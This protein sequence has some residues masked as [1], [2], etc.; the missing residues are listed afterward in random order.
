MRIPFR[1]GIVRAPSNFLQLTSGKV[2]LSIPPSQ[3]LIMAFADGA[4]DYLVT[5]RLSAA[6]AWTGPFVGGSQS[7]WLFWDL[8]TVTGAKTYGHTLLEPVEGSVAPVSPLNDQHWFD[9]V[10]NKM[11]VWNSTVSRWIPKIRVFAGKL[12]NGAIFVSMSIS[13][14]VYTG[15]QIGNLQSIAVDAGAL[16]FDADGY[17]VKKANGTFLTTEDVVLTGVASSSHVKFGSIVLEAEATESIA[18]FSIVRFTDFNQVSVATNYVLDNAAYGIV[19]VDANSGDVVSITMEGLISNSDWDWSAAGINA[20]LY[21]DI[22]GALTTVAPPTPIAVAAV[23]DTTSILLRPSSLF[24]NSGNDPATTLDMGSVLLSVA[25]ADVDLPIA[26]GDNDPRVT[27]TLA[28]ISDAASHL[29][30]Q[31]NT[32]LDGVTSVTGGIVVRR[33]TDGVGIN[34]TLTAPAAGI[35]ITNPTGDL[36]NPT[37]ALANDLA[38]VEGLAATGLA[39][40]TGT[41]TWATRSVVTSGPASGKGV[42]VTNGDAVAGNVSLALDNDAGAIE[43]LIGVGLPVRIADD[44]W[45]I[46]TVVA[47]ADGIT[48]TNGDGV[49]GDFT[50]A[51]SDDLAA[52]EALTGT[53]IPARTADDTW[54]VRTLAA[55]A[56]GLTITN[57]AGVAGNPTF[58]LANDLAAVEALGTTG[59][60]VRS[61]ADTWK[62]ASVT[63]QSG[64]VTVTNGTGITADVIVG[65]TDVGT[66]VTASF[67]KVT[68]DS[69][70]RVTATTAPTITDISTALGYTPLNKAGDTMSGVL[71]M[72]SQLISGVAN[73]VGPLDAANKQY[74]DGVA[75]GLDTKTS[76]RAATTANIALTATQVVDGVS[77]LVGNRV[78]VRAQTDQ[79]QNGIWVVASGSWTRATDALPGTT[80]NSGAYAFVEEGTL[81]ANSGWVLATDD[82]IVLNVTDLTFEQFSGAGQIIP[83][84]GMTKTG[85]Q[86]DVGTASTARIVVNANDLDL[87]TIGTPG[88]YRTVVTDAYGRVTSGSNPTTLSGHGITD[89]QP[90]DGDLTALSGMSTFGIATRTSTDTWTT[91]T[92]TGVANQVTITTGDGVSAN[93]S[94]G[95][96]SNLIMPGTGGAYVPAGTTGQEGS[97]TNGG[98]RYDSSLTK[99]RMV[100]GG[101]WKDIG[102]VRTISV[103]NAAAGLTLTPS[104][105]DSTTTV[106]VALANDLAGLEG[107]ST[108]GMAVRT[109]NDT[110]TT[111]VVAGTAGRVVVTNGSGVSSDPT[112]DLATNVIGTPGTY[113]SLTVDTYGRVTAG[114][115]PTTL[116]GYAIT[117]AQPLSTNLTNFVANVTTGI[118][119]QTGSGTFS[120][121]T[122]IAPS[123]GMSITNPTGAGG[124]PTFVLAND[125]AAIEALNS[126]G[127]A[128]RTASDTWAQRQ[129]TGTANKIS[130]TN[131]S[132]ASGDPEIDIAATY[133]GQTSI[134][135]LGTVTTGTWN[136]TPLTPTY[137]GTGTTA[138]GTTN[139]LLGVNAAGAAGEYKTL[140]GTANQ[141]VV[142]HAANSITLSLPQSIGPTSAV[143]FGSVTA[144]SHRTTVAVLTPAASL[145]WDMSNGSHATITLD[146][147]SSLANPTNMPSA[148][149]IVVL[150]VVQDAVGG[151]TLSFGT[152]FKFTGGTAPVVS[153]TANQVTMLQFWCDGTNLFELSRALNVA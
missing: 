94:I 105:S 110:W 134:T 73:P 71:N 33:T 64:E 125:L 153:A 96:A 31:Q 3:T 58:A 146:Q 60:A 34:R 8:N 130:I 143:T 131:G 44:T 28:H 72:G 99:M 111:R 70:G 67:V 90:L 68:T 74:V 15:T 36:G 126:T 118:I 79:T 80:L 27:S 24:L 128:V 119:A 148:G 112:I 53:G 7:Y 136:G 76:V 124:N 54:A 45:A 102:T 69:K 51:P 10:A 82:P 12:N 147:A 48:V 106:T 113:R 144:I 38:A 137:G 41:D 97:A 50:L 19:D 117:D 39:T 9:T 56:A 87:A 32:F 42:T 85:N 63:G 40:R 138:L 98:L 49:A 100:E 91:R 5:E 2:S 37:F 62:T 122:L 1:Q 149:T 43:A 116:A 120:S 133:V 20:P 107:L 65:L 140:N 88:S 121:R 103:T 115:N 22:N 6:N 123:E 16:V 95:L 101:A 135:T 75:A 52:V 47:T 129:L 83:G 86:L 92:I 25:P 108:T 81:Y 29:T 66:P 46:R 151:R 4:A 84:A 78:L 142:N 152:A 109:A 150:K 77:L 14:P 21:V 55:P 57:P 104:V 35:A 89:G 93:P 23:V 141:V 61:G 30:T 26:V 13:S 11:K 127:F 139:Q 132:G 114:T 59:F 18:A 145:T 17:I